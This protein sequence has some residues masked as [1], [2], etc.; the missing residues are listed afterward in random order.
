MVLNPLNCSNLE[1]LAL[2]G[3][4]TGIRANEWLLGKESVVRKIKPLNPAC[5]QLCDTVI[6]ILYMLDT[7]AHNQRICSRAG[8]WSRDLLTYDPSTHCLL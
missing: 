1:E 5:F 2:K 3:L 6:L 8:S 7:T 4:L